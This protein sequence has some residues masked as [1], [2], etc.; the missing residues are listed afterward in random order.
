MSG[1]VSGSYPGFTKPLTGTP[2]PVPRPKD[3]DGSR[4]VHRGAGP[5]PPVSRSPGPAFGSPGFVLGTPGPAP[6]IPGNKSI[7]MS[8]VTLDNVSPI[9]SRNKARPTAHLLWC[10]VGTPQL[11]GRFPGRAQAMFMHGACPR[12]ARAPN[13]FPPPTRTAE[14]PVVVPQ[15]PPGCFDESA[16]VVARLMQNLWNPLLCVCPPPPRQPT[17][18]YVAGCDRLLVRRVAFFFRVWTTN[19]LCAAFFR[20]FARSWPRP[21]TSAPPRADISTFEACES[22]MQLHGLAPALS[23]APNPAPSPKD[24]ETL[25][26]TPQAFKILSS[27]DP[28]VHF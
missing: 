21:G 23:R 14:Q 8:T 17:I 22:S 16:R 15:F 19:L 1:V 7:A 5:G 28:L 11:A 6:T 26:N 24:S 10:A 13:C 25:P 9:L 27:T 18:Y 12:R 20:S 4:G 3:R 2:G